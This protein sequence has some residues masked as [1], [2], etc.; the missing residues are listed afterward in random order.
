MKN[1]IKLLSIPTKY[2]FLHQQKYYED[3]KIA[4][5]DTKFNSIWGVVRFEQNFTD[6]IKIRFE[7]PTAM[8]VDNIEKSIVL[9]S[10][11]MS[12]NY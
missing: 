8:S 12:S 10:L 1:T 6:M 7:D 2:L 5:D 11:D 4:I 3:E 9:S